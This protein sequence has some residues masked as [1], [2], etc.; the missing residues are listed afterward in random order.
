MRKYEELSRWA[1]VGY[2]LG[3]AGVV[4]AIFGIVG[5]GNRPTGAP[6]GAKAP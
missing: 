4:M 3:A 2:G 1:I 6:R 5:M